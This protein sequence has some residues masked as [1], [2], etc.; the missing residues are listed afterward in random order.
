MS[1]QPPKRLLLLAAVG[2]GVLGLGGCSSET[3][4]E[5]E[6]VAMPDPAS[7][8]GT[9]ILHLWQGA[10]IAALAVGVLVWGLILYAVVR[11]RRR[12]DDEIPIQTRYNLPLEILYTIAP[13]I[14]VIVFFAHTVK[15]QNTVLDDD[16]PPG[17]TIEVVGQQWS[18]TFNYG[19][20]Q[21][22]NAANED[23]TDDRFPYSSYVHDSGTASHI[24]DLYLP[25]DVTT[26]FNLHSPDVIHDLGVPAFLMK[27]DVIPG[28]VN[29]Y[30]ITPT[31][32][33][34]YAGK[35][36]ELCGTYHSRMLFNVHVVS[37]AD[38]DAY[39]KALA[40]AGTTTD[41]PVLG[42]HYARTQ[43]GLSENIEGEA[44]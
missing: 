37:Q 25:V 21:M 39:L 31:E 13:V 18:W 10:W 30:A 6:R 32:I 43:V 26:R 7:E 1:L 29:H 35:C 12:S 5:W 41:L 27:M 16:T 28:R 22:D 36:Y 11:F 3:R 15:T 4:G 9:Y 24:P 33:G 17:N 23:A 34:D 2:I 20:G 40:D 42:G 14:M 38:Y 44:Q 8:Q 19:L